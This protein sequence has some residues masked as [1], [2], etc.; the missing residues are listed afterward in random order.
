M[1]LWNKN[2][3]REIGNLLA[4]K[5]GYDKIVISLFDDTN[6]T[7]DGVKHMNIID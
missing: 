4:I 5:D 3:Q 6:Q 2:K 7:F 1:S